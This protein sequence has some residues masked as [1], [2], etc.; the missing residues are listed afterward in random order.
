MKFAA[1]QKALHLLLCYPKAL[2]IIQK[3]ARLST[4]SAEILKILINLRAAK[5]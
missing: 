4:V 5:F 2:I 3:A 1:P